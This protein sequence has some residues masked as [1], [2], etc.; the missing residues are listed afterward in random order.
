MKIEG[1]LL[2]DD[3]ALDVVTK[4]K[5]SALSKIAVRLGRRTGLDEQTIL[6]GLLSREQAGSTALGDGVAIP[7]ALLES[8]TDPVASLTRLVHPIDFDAPDSSRVDLLFT[9]LWP[10]SDIRSFLPVLAQV[11]RVFR[12]ETLRDLLR[13]AQSPAAVLA[14]MR[15]K[16]EQSTWPQDRIEP[17]VETSTLK[18]PGSP[19]PAIQSWSAPLTGAQPISRSAPLLRADKS[20]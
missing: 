15:L 5:Q 19:P 17:I 6:S 18:P 12:H 11:C 3:I 8:L 4:G 16:P 9:L 13:Q 2:E 10:Q 1:L 7:H 14:V 20:P